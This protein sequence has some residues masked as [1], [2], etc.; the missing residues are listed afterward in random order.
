[1]M[2]P[3]IPDASPPHPA[4]DELPITATCRGCGYLLRGLIEPICPECGRAF[5]PSDPTSY[6]PDPS[7]RNRRR[8][9]IR[10]ST[11][12]VVAVVGFFI[13]P[14]GINKGDLTL[15]CPGCGY[16][17]IVERWELAPPSWIPVR[18]PGYTSSATQRT[19]PKFA[20]TAP[21][22][23]K[24]PKLPPSGMLSQSLSTPL[25]EEH[26]YNAKLRIKNKGYLW[27]N[28]AKGRV[29]LC[30]GMRVH[31]GTAEKI[32]KSLMAPG[33]RSLSISSTSAKP[34]D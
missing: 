31:P 29:P 20:N 34:S 25:C 11:A 6:V 16:Q 4:N 2:T 7:V 19:N 32:L 12:A 21:K 23:A 24:T 17:V 8:W 26:Y 9:I 13:F 33:I 27:V 10:I 28:G 5:D 30:N 3:E 18:Y 15:T 1:M 22:F 14:R